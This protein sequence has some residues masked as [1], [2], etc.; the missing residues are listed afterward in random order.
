[1]KKFSYAL[2]I[3]ICLFLT[4]FAAHA[5]TITRLTMSGPASEYITQ[6]QTINCTLDDGTFLVTHDSNNGISIMFSTPTRPWLWSVQ[7]GGPHASTPQVGTYTNCMRYGF[8]NDLPGLAICGDGRCGNEDAGTFTVKQVVYTNTDVL[9]LWVVF[10][11]CCDNC[12]GKILH[13]EFLYNIDSSTP[14]RPTSWGQLKLFY[15]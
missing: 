6:G 14:T 1:M 5:S 11:Q 4:P 12:S 13:G 9:S 3:M 10:D 2:F 15:R 8:N 7:F